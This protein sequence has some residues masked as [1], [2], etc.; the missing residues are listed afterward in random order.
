MYTIETQPTI[1]TITAVRLEV[2]PH[3]SLV[4]QG[5]GR[6]K[7]GNFVLT[8]FRLAVAKRDSSKPRPI[9]LSSAR[10]DFSQNDWQVEKAIN[11][12]PKDGWAISPQIG[13]RH[14]AIFHLKDPVKLVED[15]KLMVTLDQTY[16]GAGAHNIGRFRLSATDTTGAI[17]LDDLPVTVVKALQVSA[18]QRT[19]AQTEAIADYYRS[20]DLELKKLQA[21]VAAHAK[22]APGAGKTMAQSVTQQALSTRDSRVFPRGDFLQKKDG[23]LVTA[24][25]PSVLPPLN[26]SDKADRLGFA[27]WLVDPANP[28]TAR[29]T[30]N[31][32]WQRYFGRGIVA[33]S[34]DFGTQGDP[35]S[36]PQLLDWL[37][38][39]LCESGWH[40]K[41]IHRLI[42]NSATYR[43]QS[44]VRKQLIDVDPDNVLLARQTRMRVEAEIIRDLALSV[45]GL[46][47]AK[48]GGSSVRPPQ[49][50]EYSAL[51]YANSAKW[52]TSK[53]GDQYRR[54]MYTFFQRTSPYPM[55]MTFDSP[56]STECTAQRSKSNTPLQALTIW[57]DPVFVECAQQLGR[58]IVNESLQGVSADI[59]KRN[60]AAYA[61]QLC[62]SRPPN[63]FETEVI[64]DLYDEQLEMSV[65]DEKLTAAIVGSSALPDRVTAVELSGWIAIGRTLLNL[66]EFITRE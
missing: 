32:I 2:L 39:E 55:L 66:D 9:E 57:N 50:S 37:A 3:K 26:E 35:P 27:R 47:H 6:A 5:P 30:V 53:G 15:A 12:D 58:R 25:V 7:N 21:V 60:R 31:R 54:G 62:F 65:A 29:V 10:A 11:S 34:D 14:V 63:D 8:T 42:V 4:K 43:Q 18:S 46:L 33:S 1:K 41:H 20:I 28:L 64:L 59:T 23:A 61:F 38:S 13:K 52:Q 19:P 56:D 51:T 17:D 49:P 16:H 44:A 45:S 48:I 36:H 24:S 22:K 40:L